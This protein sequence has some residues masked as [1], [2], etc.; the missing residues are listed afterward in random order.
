MNCPYKTKSISSDI[1]IML[2]RSPNPRLSSDHAIAMP[3]I[4]LTHV[5]QCLSPMYKQLEKAQ[6]LETDGSDQPKLASMSVGTKD[7]K[8]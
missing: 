4:A 3:L 7:E 1:A 2:K 8:L 5:R 6:R